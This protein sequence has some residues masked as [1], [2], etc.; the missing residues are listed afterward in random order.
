MAF[1]L[2]VSLFFCFF[3]RAPSPPRHPPLLSARPPHQAVF[4]VFKEV[5]RPQVSLVRDLV[6]AGLHPTL[7]GMPELNADAPP[8]ADAEGAAGGTA[9]PQPPEVRRRMCMC[10]RHACMHVHPPTKACQKKVVLPSS[11]S[12]QSSLSLNLNLFPE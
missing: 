7:L 3:C 8:P 9:Q 10:T 1:L 5:R 4:D 11:T 2:T 12:R 6:S